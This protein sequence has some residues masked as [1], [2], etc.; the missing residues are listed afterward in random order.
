[1]TF[2]SSTL[3]SYVRWTTFVG[4]DLDISFYYYSNQFL[5]VFGINWING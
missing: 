4:V 3:S 5:V 1:M 2:L